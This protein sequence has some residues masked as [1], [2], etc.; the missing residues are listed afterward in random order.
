MMILEC[1]LIEFLRKRIDIYELGKLEKK[2]VLYIFGIKATEFFV[3]FIVGLAD[4]N[5]EGE[6]RSFFFKM[7]AVVF[8]TSV[9]KLF[10]ALNSF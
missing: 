7:L 6:F 10:C 4:E 1:Y 3:F 9:L 2:Y 5:N 8:A